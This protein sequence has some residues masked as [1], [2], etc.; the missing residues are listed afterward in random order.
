MQI[1]QK[2]FH[3]QWI[4]KK[5]TFQSLGEYDESHRYHFH[6]MRLLLLQ[7]SV[8][9]K[10]L[11]PTRLKGLSARMAEFS[12]RYSLHDYRIIKTKMQMA[13]LK[14]TLSFVCNTSIIYIEP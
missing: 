8:E 2:E 1:K 5:E 10:L 6:P 14:P 3:T 13:S 12:P 9:V 7:K 4:N 11:L